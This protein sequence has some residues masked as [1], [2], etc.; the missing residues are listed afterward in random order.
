MKEESISEVKQTK[1]FLTEDEMIQIIKDFKASGMTRTQFCKDNNHPMSNFYYWQTRYLDKFPEERESLKGKR[2]R[3]PKS[4]EGGETGDVKKRKARS[5]KKKSKRTPIKSV[6]KQEAATI[7]T[8]V[9][10]T[11][12]KRRGRP[13]KSDQA[14]SDS[15]VAKKSSQPV[16]Q[17]TDT[18]LRGPV[19]QIRY[20]SGIRINVPANID[21]KRLKELME[22]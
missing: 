11:E 13:K 10:S 1:T 9:A 18:P 3:K 15:P 21:I 4:A 20:P 6:K 19:I 14:K 22:L 16:Q 8:A 5:K 12:Q 2:G 7:E 17:P